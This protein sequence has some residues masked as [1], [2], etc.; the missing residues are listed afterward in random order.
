MLGEGCKATPV[1]CL[2]RGKAAGASGAVGKWGRN[3]DMTEACSEGWD[4][5]TWA[6]D[7]LGTLNAARDVAS[8]SLGLGDWGSG[9]DKAG[10]WISWRSKVIH[11]RIESCTLVP[12]RVKLPARAFWG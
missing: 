11:A 12:G 3:Q 10:A 5:D 9:V 6:W 1:S 2:V 7:R 8:L 4:R